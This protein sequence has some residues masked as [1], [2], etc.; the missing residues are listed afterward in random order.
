MPAKLKKYRYDKDMR[1]CQTCKFID[2]YA[3]D[4]YDGMCECCK[5]NE[6]LPDTAENRWIV[7]R[8]WPACGKY[9]KCTERQAEYLDIFDR[10]TQT[11]IEN[12]YLTK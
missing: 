1:I 4:N 11:I 6:D 5:Y 3:F 9:E 10:E 8:N 12:P 7:A 2:E